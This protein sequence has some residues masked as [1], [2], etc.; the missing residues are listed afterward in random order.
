MSKMLFKEDEVLVAYEDS[1][2]HALNAY[3]DE[4]SNFEGYATI[5]EVHPSNTK[6]KI[7]GLNFWIPIEL[8]VKLD[9]TFQ[10]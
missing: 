8:I 1:D 10:G 6:V 9:D 4:A 5:R 7:Y 2:S 3:F